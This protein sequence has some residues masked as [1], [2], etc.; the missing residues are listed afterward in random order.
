MNV[1][2]RDGAVANRPIYVVLA[3]TSDGHREN[4]GLWAGDGGE[5]A[6]YWQNILAE[7]QNRGVRDVLMLVCDGLK[8]LPEAVNTVFPQTVVQLCIV[9]LIRTT[10]KYISRA[11]W[12]KAA[13]DLRPVT[14]PPTRKR[15]PPGSPSSARNGRPST[16]PR[17]AP[18][19][20]PGARWCPSSASPPRSGRFIST[21]NAIES[22]NARYRRSANAC[23][24]FPNETRPPPPS[25]STS[26]RRSHPAEGQ[27]VGN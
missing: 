2:I 17:S 16:P 22:L 6:K 3:V 15:P 18:G 14:R 7:L 13:R 19:N 9:H 25:A 27:A 4:L 1:K 26:P 21:T 12:D 20:A 23:G 5:G 8:G 11:D 24:H 10:L